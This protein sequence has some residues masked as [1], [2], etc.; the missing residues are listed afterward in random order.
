VAA[1]L[2]V[3]TT[4]DA[5]N[6]DTSSV[7]AL[8]AN[9]GADGVSLREAIEA[10]NN[11]PGSNTIRFVSALRHKTVALRSDLPALTGGG[12]TI[13]GSGVTLTARNG[14]VGFRISS[15]GN[16]LHEFV[17]NAFDFGVVIQ[18]PGSRKTHDFANHKTFADNAVNG[19]VMR[20][21]RVQV[22]LVDSSG[23]GY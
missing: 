5:T 3:T 18:P 23:A 16:R 20:G 6:G 15:S 9:P 13:E 17:L 19:L 2:T 21:I 10:T 8:L 11:D 12:V 4:A 1:D 14:M 22:I 7:D